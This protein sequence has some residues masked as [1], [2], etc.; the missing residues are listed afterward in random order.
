MKDIYPQK[1][2]QEQ[3]LSCP[4]DIVIYGGAAGGG[5]TFALLMECLRW[6]HVPKFSAVIFRKESKQVRNPGGLW[7]TST[8]LYTL[9]KINAHPRESELEWIFKSGAK[10]KF[11]HLGHDSDKF[12]W[13]G[14]QIPLIA[15][16]ELTH[17][18]W[19][20]FMYMLSRNRSVSG[21]PSYIRATTNPDPDSWVR[22][23][24]S[25]WIDDKTGYA[26]PERSGIIRWFVVEND[27]IVWGETKEELLSKDPERLP[28][29]FS[30]I[31]ST[32]FDNQILLKSDPGYLS[33]LKA[34][35]RFERE[36][37]LMGNW[38]VRPTA[39]LFF[40]RHSFE[41]VEAVPAN[42]QKIRYWDRAATKKTE[43]NDPDFTVGIKLEKDINNILYITDM[44][45]IQETPLGVQNAIRNTAIRDGVTVRVGIEEDPGQ[46]G[47]SE[48]DH[49]ARFLQGFNVKRNRVTK[50]KVTRSLP[51]SAQAEAGNV[52]VLRAKW[53]EDF[54]RELENFPDAAHDDIVD[55]LSGAFLMINESSY[56]LSSLAR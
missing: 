50:D 16:D 1:G 13:Q 54:F 14:A 30:F 10:V 33:S 37:L 27:A 9:K 15:F 3:F 29:S 46:A 49:L 7:D 12:A 8:S 38:N 51:V 24:I 5:K 28:K 31:A 23:M 19:S 36:Q 34:L 32:I 4:A 55:A 53:N 6:V 56:N 21:V 2:P 11:A 22:R 47:V 25:W 39:G 26:I 17:F 48:A 40:Q 43:T 45:R 41:I 20:L 52:K 35:S 18:S 44:I 42:T